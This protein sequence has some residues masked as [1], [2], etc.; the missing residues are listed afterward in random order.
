MEI[1][2]VLQI[3]CGEL[4]N[5]LK[6]IFVTSEREKEVKVM[7][8]VQ[9]SHFLKFYMFSHLARLENWAII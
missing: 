8:A 7:G 1:K 6:P 3:I 4:T 5:V 2:F 9:F